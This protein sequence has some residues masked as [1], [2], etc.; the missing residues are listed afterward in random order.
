MS[1]DHPF[2]SS[3]MG[4]RSR[5]DFYEDTGSQYSGQRDVYQPS[6]DLSRPPSR[7]P[8]SRAEEA[9]TSMR[10]EVKSILD[11]CGL[12]PSDLSLLAELPEDLIN[13]NTLPHLLKKLWDSKKQNSDSPA[14]SAPVPAYERRRL[15]SPPTRSDCLPRPTPSSSRDLVRETWKDHDVDQRHASISAHRS[16]QRGAS[17]S[18]VVEYG[19]P[20]REDLRH[21]RTPACGSEPHQD[22]ISSSSRRDIDYRHKSLKDDSGSSYL[23][24]KDSTYHTLPSKKEASDFHGSTPP[25]FP[26]ACELCEIAV[27]SNKDWTQHINSAQHADSQLRLLQRY[28]KW[29]CHVSSYRRDDDHPPQR[30]TAPDNAKTA[31]TQKRSSQPTGEPSNKRPNLKKVPEKPKAG[32]KVISVRFTAKSID[33][34]YLRRLL[35]Q[36]G[37]IIKIIMFPSLA[38]VEMGSKDQAGDIEKYFTSNPLEV[39]GSKVVFAISESFIFLKSSKVVCFSPLPAGDGITSEVTAAA[40]QF[41]PLEDMLFLPS[42]AYIEMSEAAHAEALVKHHAST[43]LKLKGSTIQVDFSSEYET[44]KD[45][46]ERSSKSSLPKR[47][48]KRSPSPAKSHSPKRSH[49]SKSRSRS[50]RRGSRDQKHCKEKT[51]SSENVSGSA[52]KAVKPK[53]K[54]DDKLPEPVPLKKEEGEEKV[55]AETQGKSEEKE[56]SEM[57]DSDSDLEGVAVIAEDDEMEGVE[58]LDAVDSDASTAGR[59]GD[60]DDDDDEEEEVATG[61]SGQKQEEEAPAPIPEKEADEVKLQGAEEPITSESLSGASQSEEVGVC[62]EA[63][64]GEDDRKAQD[65]AEPPQDTRGDPEPSAEPSKETKGDQESCAPSQKEAAATVPSGGGEGDV[66]SR[67]EQGEGVAQ[68]VG[69]AAREAVEMQENT[70]DGAE[71]MQEES[72]EEEEFDFPDNLENLITLDEIEDEEPSE[73]QDTKETQTSVSDK[74]VL[75]LRNLPLSYYTDEEFWKIGKRYGNVAQYFLIRNRGEGFIEMENGDDAKKAV[76]DLTRRKFAFHGCTLEIALSWKYKK[77]INAWVPEP[78]KK[79][80]R[81]SSKS[82]EHKNRSRS[83]SHS[84]SKSQ[85]KQSPSESKDKKQS[86][87]ESKDKKQSPSESK[88]KKSD[89]SKKKGREDSKVSAEKSRDKSDQEKSPSKDSSKTSGE[90]SKSSDKEESGSAEKVAANKDGIKAAPVVVVKKEENILGEYQPNTPVGQEFVRPVVGYFCNLCNAIYTTEEEAKNQHCSSLSH[91]QK[92][93]VTISHSLF[94]V[95][96]EDTTFIEHLYKEVTETLICYNISINILINLGLVLVLR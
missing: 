89:Q 40:R 1:Q 15:S 13:I 95:K 78:E 60:E 57:Y 2:R 61:E 3:R 69:E 88:D 67:E 36:F 19:H 52:E 59:K 28:P 29:D 30:P 50:P 54:P 82:N 7:Q 11:S 31:K 83:R 44:L 37:A 75:C 8:P 6:Q 81:R 85:S 64:N 79:H 58:I 33:E 42:R 73:E 16:R 70:K 84:K 23:S 87:S 21:N 65:T 39:E 66:D 92:L 96:A 74:R 47:H 34:A 20:R 45:A 38:F 93:K 53:A 10:P 24:K 48:A 27:L 86:P 94:E 55:S 51:H 18:H 46:P 76:S 72:S 5:D 26:Y 63:A 43:P 9:Y 77:L 71:D 4:Y 35:G 14:S 22:R 17:G 49:R 56:N 62:E 90:E 41:G 12:E 25:C 80:K 91:F 68:D 32:G